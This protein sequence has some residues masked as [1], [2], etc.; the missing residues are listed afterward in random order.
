MTVSPVVFY[1][2]EAYGFCAPGEARDFIADGQIDLDGRIPV[3][4]HGGLLGEAYIHGVNNILEA[5]RQ[6]RGT[7]V[8][9]VKKDVHR[10]LVAAGRSAVILGDGT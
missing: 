3:N 7:A 2:L 1:M 9:Q 6:L 4:T 8:N 10:A 5:V